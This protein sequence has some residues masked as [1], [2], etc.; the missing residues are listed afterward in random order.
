MFFEIIK[1]YVI[2]IQNSFFQGRKF[3][4]YYSSIGILAF[5]VLII[6]NYDVLKDLTK[7]NFSKV[8][9]SYRWFI[10]SVLIF[11]LADILWGG[12][13]ALKIKVFAYIDTNLFFVTMMLSVFLWTRYVIAYLDEKNWFSKLLY[14]SGIIIFIYEVVILVINLFIPFVFYFDSNGEYHTSIARFINLLI[15]IGLFCLTTIYMLVVTAKSKGMVKA[16][17]RT[18]G[19]FGFAM[20][21]SIVLQAFY[22]FMPFY[23][24]GLMLG[25]CLLRTFVLEDEKE[26]RRKLLEELIQKEQI[27]EYELGFARHLAYTDP[28]TGVKN[29]ASYIDEVGRTELLI[30][31]EKISEFGV[32]VFDLN[33]LKKIND[34]LGHE[35][36]DEYIK[37]ACKI[38]CKYFKHSPVFRIGGDEFV[39]IIRGDDYVNHKTIMEKFTAQILEEKKKNGVIIASGFSSFKA[40]NDGSFMRVF[41]RAD[42]NMYKCKKM[43]KEL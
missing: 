12:F 29:K 1:R 21:I 23:S 6:S 4:L 27:Q 13:Y 5:L 8:F 25:L 10:I 22:P 38:I 35:K 37:E 42:K 16:R 2:L 43:L 31:D 32:A 41:E 3:S 18:I 7:K 36:G 24:I 15:Q 34:T 40:G 20:T 17:H 19:F 30:A 9:V 39:T 11:Y 26:E 33:G 28:L 14:W